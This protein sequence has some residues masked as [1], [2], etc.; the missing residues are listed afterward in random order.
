MKKLI[1]ASFVAA[2]FVACN[3]N[4]QPEANADVFNASKWVDSIIALQGITYDSATWASYQD[5]FNAATANIDTTKLSAE[6]KTLFASA[7]QKWAD[8]QTS[9]TTKINEAKMAADTTA[10]AAIANLYS[11]AAGLAG[12]SMKDNKDFTFLTGANCAAVYDK[13]L[14]ALKDRKETDWTTESLANAKAFYEGM[15]S[16]KNSIE[17]D[18]SAGDKLKVGALKLKI[19]SF[20]GG[21]KLENKS[22]GK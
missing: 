10:S 20:F 17:K 9:F 13:F 19:G 6:D 3:N 18:M 22:E 15:D 4:T 8:Y 14:T 11:D 5:A 16:Y 12:V 1:V 2:S 21:Q 7:A